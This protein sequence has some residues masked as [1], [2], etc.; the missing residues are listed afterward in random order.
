MTIMAIS[1]LLWVTGAVCWALFAVLLAWQLCLTARRRIR[2]RQ[3]QAGD[4][5]TAV[6]D[7]VQQDPLSWA[8]RMI[9]AKLHILAECVKDDGQEAAR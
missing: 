3:P 1:V 4:G 2:P 8:E 7:A 5:L 9:P 6:A